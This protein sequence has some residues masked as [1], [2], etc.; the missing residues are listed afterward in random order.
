[1][2]T[3][4]AE[5]ALVLLLR[6]FSG[7]MILAIF[8]VLLPSSWLQ[9]S[10]EYMEPGTKVGI[11]L[12]YLARG[13]SAFYFLLG[14]LIWLFST[15]I[16]RYASAARFIFRS[17]ILLA[18]GALLVALF[19]ILTSLEQPKAPIVWFALFNLASAFTFALIISL[20]YRRMNLPLTPSDKSV[21]DP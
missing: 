9:T 14:G 20:L 4:R 18:G 6:L 15:D 7:F 17:Y 5:R 12:Q 19:L 3:G 8:A 2:K 16:P 11:L 13:W 1:M 10:V 21:P